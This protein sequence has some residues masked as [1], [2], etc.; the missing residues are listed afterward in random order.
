[1]R[2]AALIQNGKA[3]FIGAF[4]ELPF[5]NSTALASANQWQR[6]AQSSH[7]SRL[8][9]FLLA[10]CWPLSLL[11]SWRSR[12]ERLAVERRQRAADQDG[13]ARACSSSGHVNVFGERRLLSLAVFM[14][15]RSS[16]APW[17]GI[18]PDLYGPFE[19]QMN[20]R[21]ARDKTLGRVPAQTEP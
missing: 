5:D 12:S 10:H 7:R 6:S 8:Q 9:V 15:A 18:R 1:M 16:R 11:R 4:E 13:R 20:G 3:N 21:A 19:G 2:L 17:E 14:V